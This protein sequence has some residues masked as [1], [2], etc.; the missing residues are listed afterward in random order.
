MMEPNKTA[1]EWINTCEYV[2][3]SST[4]KECPFCERDALRAEVETE[5]MRLVA[6]G[7]IA[8][9]NTPE[10]ARATRIPKDNPYYSA[11]LQD[12]EN[13]VDRE[14]QLRADLAAAVEVLREVVEYGHHDTCSSSLVSGLVDKFDCSCP[15][16][17][18]VAFL[19]R[20]EV[21]P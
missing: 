4:F 14:I 2:H 20:M 15:H 3:P 1:D 11:S 10:S 5:H 12:V 21:K 6:C 18:A 17:L 19:A 7:V 16:K 13:A 9:A 8:M